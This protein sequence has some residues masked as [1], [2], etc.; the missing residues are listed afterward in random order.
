MTKE[1]LE[2]LFDR[3]RALPPEKLV[4]V[5]EVLEWLERRDSSIYVLTEEERADLDDALA[6]VDRGEV[7]TAEEVVAVFGR[8]PQSCKS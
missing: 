6:E 8:L 2:S 4:E 5:E 3:I 7:A 1:E